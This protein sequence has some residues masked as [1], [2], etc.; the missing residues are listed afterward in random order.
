MDIL[1][2]CITQNKRIKKKNTMRSDRY[3]RTAMSFKRVAIPGN[4]EGP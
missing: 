1:N 4:T 2:K 3:W